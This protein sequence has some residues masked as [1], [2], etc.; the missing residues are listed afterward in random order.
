MSET[1]YSL[2]LFPWVAVQCSLPHCRQLKPDGTE[3]SYYERAN[4]KA[5]LMISATMPDVGLPYGK[6]PRMLLAHV[7]AEY[8]RNLA[9]RSAREARI[10][11]LGRSW[12]GFMRSLGMAR[13]GS[14]TGPSA[15][16]REQATRLFSASIRS[17]RLEAPLL[18]FGLEWETFTVARGGSLWWEPSGP[19]DP[20]ENYVFLSEGFAETCEGPVPVRLETMRALSSPFAIDLYSWLTYRCALLLDH[21]EPFV[22]ITWPQLQRQFGHEAR[23]GR[24]FREKFRRNL[25]KVLEHYPARVEHSSWRDGIVVYAHPPDVPRR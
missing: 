23:R 6:V 15:R 7:V 25:R 18:R 3:L 12:S 16:F 20:R 19:R 1:K 22:E 2:G 17:V 8:K 10:I 4:G 24:K 11:D 13:G 14:S 9:H 21:Q 5:R